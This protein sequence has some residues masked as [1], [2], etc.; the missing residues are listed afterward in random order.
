MGRRGRGRV[1]RGEIW[2][3]A[4]RGS[5]SGK[6]RPVVIVQDDRF[7]ATGSVTVCPM[8]TSAVDAPL[9]RIPVDPA[10]GIARSSWIMVDKVTT[11]P[12]AGVRERVG[13]LPDDEL[14]RLNRALLAFLGLAG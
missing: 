10:V 2:T 13:R 3:A 6:P 7:D 11:V 4:A 5:Y 1:R 8:T 12:R 9:L 14:V